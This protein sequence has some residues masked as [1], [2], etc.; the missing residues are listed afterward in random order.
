MGEAQDRYR[1][2]AK[3]KQKYREN[4]REYMIVWRERRKESENYN[5]EEERRKWREQH[6]LVRERATARLG[7]KKC[8][9]CGL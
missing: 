9:N 2:T 5:Q 8:C 6:K 1:A 3:G 7:G 4:M